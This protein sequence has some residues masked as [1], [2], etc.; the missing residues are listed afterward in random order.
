MNTWKQYEES[1]FAEDL[2]IQTKAS[3]SLYSFSRTS[4]WFS[5]CALVC[6]FRTKTNAHIQKVEF[7]QHTQT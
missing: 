5:L 7:E 2:H 4:C 6:V 1:S 3:S